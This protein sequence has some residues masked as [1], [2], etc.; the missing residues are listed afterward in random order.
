MN[1]TVNAQHPPSGIYAPAITFFNPATD[2]LDL[3]AQTKYYAYLAQHLH[4]LVILGTNAETFLLTRSERST[5]LRTARQAA[6]PN[7]HIMA[8]VGGH[9]TKQ[10]LE[11]MRDAADAGANSALVL[12]CAYF[13]KQTTAAVVRAFYEQVADESPLPM[14]IYNF[15]GVCN[16]IDVESD[17]MAS[18]AK[19]YPG[20]IVGC[21]LTC[22]SVAKITRLAGE[23][24]SDQFAVFG[25][26]SD[27]LLAGMAVG[28]AGCVA[29]FANVFPKTIRKIYELEKAGQ[30]VEALKLHRVAAQAELC[31]KAGIATTKYAT[32]L[33]SARAA[34]IEGPEELLR[35]RRPY[36]PPSD[37]VK[38]AIRDH[39]ADMIAIEESL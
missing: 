29:A 31:C 13:G 6:G 34:G 3:D 12:P 22:A 18:L 11:F 26:Q 14:L 8:G 15:P 21:K 39:L 38:K 7:V 35:P 9:S 1:S 2:E 30:H 25:G 32:S 4:G 24:T 33:T 16:G 17:V 27:F 20:K 37:D 10:V 19:K 23:F 36:G 5:L 28:S